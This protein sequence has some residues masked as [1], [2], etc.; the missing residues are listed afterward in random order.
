MPR[1]FGFLFLLL[2]LCAGGLLLSIATLLSAR[3][4]STLLRVGMDTAWIIVIPLALGRLCLT[5]LRHLCPEN[6]WRIELVRLALVMLGVALIS[7]HLF[8]QLG[9]TSAVLQRLPDLP[10]VPLG[11]AVGGALLLELAIGLLLGIPLRLWLQDA[12]MRRL[13]RLLR[14][15]STLETAGDLALEHHGEKVFRLR[16]KHARQRIE[17]QLEREIQRHVKDFAA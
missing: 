6:R 9:P 17:Q 16:V 5:G 2:A 14:G 3:S 1:L 4:V 7:N 10:F 8:E 15:L 11:L 13:D 12:R